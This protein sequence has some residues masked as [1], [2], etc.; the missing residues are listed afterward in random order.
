M[1]IGVLIPGF[2][3][4]TIDPFSESYWQETPAADVSGPT[5]MAPPRAPLQPRL[6][7]GGN[8]NAAPEK[9]LIGAAEGQK[10]PITSVAASQHAKRGPKPAPKTLNKEDLEEF[11]EAVVGSPLGKLELQKG[12][13]TRYVKAYRES[14][15]DANPS[16][17]FPKLTHEAIKE[18]LGTMFAQRGLGK[19]DKKWVFVGDS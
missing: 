16:N 12:L 17:R 15:I 1:R 8:S 5:L 9:N 3:G 19:A 13:K 18:T 14:Q 4:A 2:T 10:G 6:N 11:K 7:L